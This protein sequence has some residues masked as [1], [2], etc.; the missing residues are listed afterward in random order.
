MM[1]D[2]PTEHGI[3]RRKFRLWLTFGHSD[4]WG[5]VRRGNLGGRA[6]GV[7]S[8][9]SRRQTNSGAS[10]K[11]YAGGL[12]DYMLLEDEDQQTNLHGTEVAVGTS[13][14]PPR[15]NCFLERDSKASSSAVMIVRSAVTARPFMKEHERICWILSRQR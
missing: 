14:S 3:Y 5:A 12:C 4:D 1:G 11:E 9:H 8:W 2:P 7:L 15:D 10:P 6:N 13:N